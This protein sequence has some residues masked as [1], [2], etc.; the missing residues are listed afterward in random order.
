VAENPSGLLQLASNF[1]EMPMAKQAGA[2]LGIAGSVAIGMYVVL[3]AQDPIYTPVLPHIDIKNVNEVMSA[4][5]QEQIAYKLDSKTGMIM[6][7]Q[8]QLQSARIA[9]ANKGFPENSDGNGFELL[10]KS[11][12]F[13]SS[14]FLESV[15]YRRA[16]EGELGRTIASMQSV[17]SARV[18]LAIPKEAIFLKDKAKPTASVMV[19]VQQGREFQKNQVNAIV[20]LVASSIPNMEYEEVTVV[21]QNGRLL[22]AGGDEGFEVISKQLDYTRQLEKT[23]NKRILDLLTPIIGNNRI[24]AEVN[25]DVDFTSTEETQENFDPKSQ[26]LRSEKVLEEK[27]LGSGGVMGIPGAL[28]NQPAV[29]GQAPEKVD[30]SQPTDPATESVTGPVPTSNK[31]QATRNYELDK[32]IRLVRAQPGKIQRLSVAVLVDDKVV[33]DKKG[34]ET[35]Q[36]FTDDELKKIENVVK[37]AIGFEEKRGDKVS[38]VNSAFIPEPKPELDPPDSI[39]N[40]AWVLPFAKQILAGLFILILV[41]RVFRPFFN[42]MSEKPTKS[43]LLEYG[44]L[45]AG[46]DQKLVGGPP[47]MPLRLPNLTKPGEASLAHVAEMVKEDPKRVAKVIMNWVGNEDE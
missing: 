31:S 26:V 28:S 43:A 8:D 12:P 15:R 5:E 11:Q 39:F 44:V 38:V 32:S 21:D 36:P 10:D 14:Q 24:R 18:H 37:D 30:P 33:T 1:S 23:L 42:K 45:P 29:T 7:G 20:H 27:R 13:G 47:E 9:L 3:W 4:L 16:L 34:K 19:E 46:G 41:L 22:S 40:Q 35:K 25:A 17:K 2:L 6:V